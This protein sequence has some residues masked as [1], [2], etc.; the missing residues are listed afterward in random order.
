M[1]A[2]KKPNKVILVFFSFLTMVIGCKN[3]AGDVYNNYYVLPEPTETVYHV[4]YDIR[5]VSTSNSTITLTI[6]NV[7]GTQS[8]F[9]TADESSLGASSGQMY[10]NFNYS[11]IIGPVREGF[12]ASINTSGTASVYMAISVS[13]SNGVFVLKNAGNTGVNYTL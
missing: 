8:F 4:K 5:A 2:L 6:E 3:P 1:E 11:I 9:I 7:T 10:H 12:I 13:K